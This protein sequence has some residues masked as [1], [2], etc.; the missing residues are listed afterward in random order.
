MQD[1]I[2]TV[3]LPEERMESAAEYV[4]RQHNET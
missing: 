1:T 4:I 3:N 2:K